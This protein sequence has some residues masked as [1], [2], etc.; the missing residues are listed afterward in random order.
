MKPVQVIRESHPDDVDKK[1]DEI[2][3]EDV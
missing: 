1:K 3:K 2:N